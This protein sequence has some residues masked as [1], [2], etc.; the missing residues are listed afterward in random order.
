[1]VCT[2]VEPRVAARGGARGGG[3]RWYVVGSGSVRDF[4]GGGAH[5]TT[6][7]HTSP[8]MVGRS[9]GTCAPPPPP[10]CVQLSSCRRPGKSPCTPPEPTCTPCRMHPGGMP[11]MLLRVA[12]RSPMTKPAGG[13]QRPPG[14]WTVTNGGCIVTDGILLRM[15]VFCVRHFCEGHAVENR[16]L[17]F[18]QYNTAFCAGN[19]VCSPTN[20]YSYST[21]PT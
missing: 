13:C 3:S 8:H 2:V 14:G 19:C 17:L 18:L 16:Y 1:M 5:T 21:S 12:G 6:H 4:V 11:G 9:G 10:P 7:P 15:S 20:A